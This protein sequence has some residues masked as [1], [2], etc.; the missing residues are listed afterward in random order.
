MELSPATG[1]IQ[2]QLTTATPFPDQAVLEV[3]YSGG[4]FVLGYDGARD[5]PL[6]GAWG[7]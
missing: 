4:A 7:E 2:D 3:R 6:V 5:R 1:A